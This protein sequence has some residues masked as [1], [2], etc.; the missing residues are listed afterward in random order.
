M[1]EPSQEERTATTAAAMPV[2]SDWEFT[3]EPVDK[4]E[5]E[6]M[7]DNSEEAQAQ[8]TLLALD[9]I[10]AT[11]D[12]LQKNNDRY[13]LHIQLIGLL[14]QADIPDQLEAARTRMHETFPLTQDL[15]LNWI[16]DAIKSGDNE[17]I[18]SL[19]D[20]AAADYLSIPIWKSFVDYV[21]TLHDD[22]VESTRQDLLKAVA[23]TNSH[24]AESHIIWNAYID[25]EKRVLEQSPSPEQVERIKA[26]YLERLGTLHMTVADTFSDYSTFITS[27]DNEHYEDLMLEANKVVSKTKSA[28][29]DRDLYELSL[30]KPETSVQDYYDY[31]EF[32]RSLKSKTSVNQVRA[33]YERAV[34]VY[35]TD[36]NLW[37]DYILFLIE[38]GRNPSYMGN[39]TYRAVRNCA[40]S[41]ILWGHRARWLE[42]QSK[43]DEQKEEEIIR[44]F[45]QALSNQTLLASLEDLVSLLYAK[46]DFVRRNIDWENVTE[47]DL[48][49][50]RLVFTEASMYIDEAF[51]ETGDPLHRIIKYW[52][53]VEHKL[54][55]DEEKARSI[56]EETVQKYRQSAEAWCKYIEFER[57]V[58]EASNCLKLCKVACS[59][60]LDEP[61]KLL[62]LWSTVEHE[63][64][65]IDSYEASL[66]TIKQKMKILARQWQKEQIFLAEHEQRTQEQKINERKKKAQHRIKNKKKQQEKKRSE[67]GDQA[68]E[69]D[70]VAP[71][72]ETEH[73]VQ[74]APTTEIA[75]PVAG[76][77]RRK[78]SVD[79]EKPKSKK[80]KGDTQLENSQVLRTPRN[81]THGRKRLQVPTAVRKNASISSQEPKS[82]SKEESKDEPK[83][84]T[85][86]GPLETKD[87]PKEPKAEK[88]NADFRAMF[89][90]K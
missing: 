27:Q 47:E 9:Q 86:D 62:D 76:V 44:V 63:M 38:K 49:E 52:T 2:A 16:N 70:Q 25:F 41:G 39:V 37:D 35:C 73:T 72:G 69:A 53:Y 61:Q 77:K 84:E 75:A 68:K 20:E 40:W 80:S 11:M 34:A 18:R 90:K 74:P 22:D 30:T 32:E 51:P 50:I 29:G 6:A 33:L 56:W 65:S 43:Q 19:Y 28:V 12:E 24:I 42:T 7:E 48:Q 85:K 17:K 66:I 15:W 14:E 46:C 10:P 59:K 87:E 81:R 13:D 67:E 26:R 4:V 71:L 60:K 23:A 21:L 55:G 83:E 5:D 89:L 88:S 1:D 45:D 54:L 79:D 3:Q 82:D 64:G 31:I 78:L 8:S 58:G 36:V 57:S